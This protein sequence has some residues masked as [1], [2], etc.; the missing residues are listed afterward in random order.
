MPRVCRFDSTER[1]CRVTF[2]PPPSERIIFAFSWTCRVS[3]W[4]VCG[5]GSYPS[6]QLVECEVIGPTPSQLAD[7]L[8]AEPDFNYAVTFG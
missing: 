1:G 5:G 2:A 6:G 3:G 4:H 7:A 8:R